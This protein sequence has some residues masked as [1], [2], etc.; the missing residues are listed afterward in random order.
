MLMNDF[1]EIKGKSVQEQN[2]QSTISGKIIINKSHKIFEGHFPNQPIV[3]G[4]CMI[5]MIKEI[6][7][8]H[9]SRKLI[10]ASAN[11]IKFLSVI[12]PEI[13]NNINFEI[14]YRGLES[15]LDVD[16]RLFLRET[17][18]FKVKGMFID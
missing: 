2:G 14:L 12:N 7:E 11:N 8:N 18:F 1:F 3:P 15:H 13:N 9:L 16:A 17:I 5:Q 4:V 10:F 6:L